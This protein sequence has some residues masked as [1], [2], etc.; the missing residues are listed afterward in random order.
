M[1][2][3]K[4][5]KSIIIWLFTGCFLVVAMVV[6]GGITRL[7]SSGLSIVEWDVVMGTLPPLNE[8]QW[9]VMFEKYKLSPQ[10]IHINND[11]SVEDFKSIFWW[12]YFH[13]LIGRII[14]M[15]FLIPFLYFYFTK[16][17]TKDLLPKLLFLFV[18]GGFQGF[19]GWF[20]VK[21]GLSKDPMVSHYRLAAHL[22]TAIL[23]FGYTFWVALSIIYKQKAQ[24]NAVT[25]KI[26]S[27]LN[28]FF[29]VV[30]LQIVYGAFVA[31]L[32]AGKICNTYPKMCD[33]WV[34]DIYSEDTFLHNIFESHVGVQFLHR[35][36]ALVVV[37]FII[38]LWIYAKKNV[39]NSVIK[40]SLNLLLLI[41]FVQFLLGIFT[42][43]YS[44]PI[45]LGV[46]HQFGAILVFAITLFAMH[47]TRYVK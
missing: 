17:I 8:A 15:V 33:Y 16:K 39:I 47:K 43:V 34:P 1:N 12:E 27:L 31:G 45:S 38:T 11:F 35:I 6:I 22:S 40:K 37:G 41:V 30:M 28:I 32:K 5:D 2:T 23:T 36:F 44:V 4:N 29:F 13:R 7:T 19:L 42:L 46:I 20:M 21:S 24:T 18:L 10:F 25:N 9:H 14:G 26:K 3:L